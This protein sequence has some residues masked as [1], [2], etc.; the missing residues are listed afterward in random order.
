MDIITDKPTYSH[1]RFD[2]PFLSIYANNTPTRFESY[3]SWLSLPSRR[4][5]R[6]STLQPLLVRTLEAQTSTFWSGWLT[7]PWILVM[8]VF[9]SWWFVF[10]RS[11]RTLHSQIVESKLFYPKKHFSSSSGPS[12]PNHGE[13]LL[14]FLFLFLFF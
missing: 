2:D 14:F 10:M 9:E 5:A 7:Y 1:Q 4:D 12:L 8:T 11:L 3:I 6:P 13:L